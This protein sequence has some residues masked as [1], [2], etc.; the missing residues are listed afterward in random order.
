MKINENV[1][2]FWL[3]HGIAA[4]ALLIYSLVCL[5]MVSFTLYG[6][7]FFMSGVFFGIGIVLIEIFVRQ[8]NPVKKE[9]LNGYSNK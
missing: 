8:L 9:V 6:I 2:R 4:M 3:S 5:V 1:K 7:L